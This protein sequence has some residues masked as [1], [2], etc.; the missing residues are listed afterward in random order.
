MAKTCLLKPLIQSDCFHSPI[1]LVQFKTRN[2]RDSWPPQIR[3]PTVIYATVI[4]LKTSNEVWGE[5]G[6][7]SSEK[8]IEGIYTDTEACLCVL[9]CRNI[10]GEHADR[11]NTL[12]FFIPWITWYSS[13]APCS[14]LPCPHH[15]MLRTTDG[16]FDLE[17]PGC[18]DKLGGAY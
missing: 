2:E 3:R 5:W 10:H 1:K 16:L 8:S 14:P 18:R 6:F 12:P 15:R 17:D 9:S 13:L 7:H 4:S 11:W